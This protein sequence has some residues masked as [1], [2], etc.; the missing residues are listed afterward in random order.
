MLFYVRCTCIQ[1]QFLK[2][3]EDMP[4]AHSTAPLLGALGTGQ[5]LPLP[6]SMQTEVSML[7][8]GLLRF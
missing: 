5:P 6:H 7:N 1:L 3:T 2:G 4:S 8:Q